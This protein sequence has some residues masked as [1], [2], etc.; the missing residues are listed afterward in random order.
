MDVWKSIHLEM[1]RKVLDNLEKREE[2]LHK[3]HSLFAPC[4]TVMDKIFLDHCGSLWI[5]TILEAQ[6]ATCFTIEKLDPLET[7]LNNPKFGHLLII[8]SQLQH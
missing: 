4:E 5:Q 8:T 7:R 6:Y 3:A 1:M 2:R